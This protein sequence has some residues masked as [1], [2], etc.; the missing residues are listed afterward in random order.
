MSSDRFSRLPVRDVL[1]RNVEVI[2]DLIE[3]H[4]TTLVFAN[5]R[6]MTEVIVQILRV[7]GMGDLVAGHHG[8]MDKKIRLGV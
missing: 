7:L 3:A 4:H 6:K 2:K 1:E 8:S 5:T